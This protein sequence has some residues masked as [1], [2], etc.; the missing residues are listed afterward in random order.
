MLLMMLAGPASGAESPPDVL[1]RQFTGHVGPFLKTYCLDCHSGEQA[2]AKLDLSTFVTAKHVADAHQTWDT[3]AE[4]LKAGEMPPADAAAHPSEDEQQAVMKWIR[5]FRAQEATRNAGDPGPVLARRLSNAEYNYTIR[6]LTGVDIRPTATFPIDPANEAGFDNSGESLAMSPALLN[7]YLEAAR[8][9]VDHLVLAPEGFRF[10]PHAVVTDTDRDK[11]CVNRIVRFYERQPT[12]Y[13]DHFFACWRYAH[14]TESDADVPLEEYARSHDVSPRYLILVWS[15]IAEDAQ[16]IGPLAKLQQMWRELPESPQQEEVARAACETMR[17]Y[18]V[19]TRQML[20]PTFPNLQ[21]GGIHKGSQAFVLWKN[22]QYAAHRM[23]F[24]RSVL[25]R[26]NADSNETLPDELRILEE[27]ETRLAHEQALTQ[28]CAVFPDAFYIS[29]R[30]RDYLDKP[31][32][33]EEKGRLLS[34]GFHSMMGYFRDDRPL[35]ELVLDEKEQRELDRLWQEL[36]FITSA[37]MRQY[38]G[39]LWFER[40]DSPFLRDP[41]FDFVRAEDKTALTEEMIYKLEDVYLAKALRE[42]A[43][44]VVIQAVKDHYRII[45]QQIRWVEQARLEAEPSHLTALLE[46]AQR[47]Y[48]RPLSEAECEELLSFYRALREEDGLGHDAALQDAIVSVLM[49]PHFCYR[50][51][52]GAA[53]DRSRPLTD[54]ELASRLSYFL[55]SSMPDAQLLERAA[56]GKLQRPEVLLAETRRMLQD[57]RVRGLATE[58]GGN[59]L[60]F[61]HFEQHNSVDRKRFP[62]FDDALRQAMFEEPVRFLVDVL[63]RNGSAL[64]L[65]YATHTFVNQPLSAHYGM[66][67]EHRPQAEHAWIRVD[68]ADRYGRGGLL[69]MA[70]FQTKNAPGLRTSPVKRGSWIVTKLLGERI[71]P[72]PPDVPELPAAETDLD[73]LSLRELLAMHRDH[74]SCAG[75][76]DRFDSIGLVFENYGPAG[77]LRERDL[78]GRAINTQA[79]FPDGSNGEG[80][81]GLRRYLQ[82]KRQ[83]DFL[84]NLCRKMLSYALGRTLLPSDDALVESMKAKSAAN[85][86]RIGTLVETIVTSRQFLNKR[87]SNELARY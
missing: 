79:T 26:L 82:E 64:E 56:A 62:Q 10:A 33:Y 85:D 49:S 55:W 61:R 25:E 83:E 29:E 81:A 40:T 11:Y 36:D 21:G 16:Q 41:E 71:P 24:D 28:F 73:T 87:G 38:S 77:E 3:I 48:R 17:D 2:E 72:P 70:V 39:Y 47:A 50:M 8:L 27:E 32:S 13:A 66:S 7:K 9:V 42:G 74:A 6:D 65:L 58:F 46:F 57:E 20:K 80:L 51:D 86:D 52:L 22:R 37:P 34:A 23:R 78:A 15:T 19:R 69:P 54:Y 43:D 75:C 30:G 59:W 68:A 35:Y 14:R 4:R 18:V 12:D 63:Q 44:E 67:D 60:D 31:N 45:N 76:H 5:D 53:E 84:D 1:A